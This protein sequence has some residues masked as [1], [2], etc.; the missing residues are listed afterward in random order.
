MVVVAKAM[1]AAAADSE[2]WLGAG[3]VAEVDWAMVAAEMVVVAALEMAV[4][5]GRGSQAVVVM[6]TAAAVVEMGM[7]VEGGAALA[8][9]GVAV[10]EGMVAAAADSVAEVTDQEN[11][12]V[13]VAAMERVSPVGKATVVATEAEVV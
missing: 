7:A 5:K 3:S 10:E 6:E 13:V 4:A 8:V 9:A 2:A 1:G 12:E 11:K